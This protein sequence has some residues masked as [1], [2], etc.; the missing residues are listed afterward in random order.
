M[1]EKVFAEW[2]NKLKI[3]WESK[4][5]QGAADLCA[6]QTLYF[7]TPFGPPLKSKQEVLKEWESVPKS[8]KDIVFSYNILSVSETMGIAHWSASFT[9]IETGKHVKLDG[10][11]QVKL[12]ESKLAEEF[13][14]WWVVK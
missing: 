2:L 1:T 6:E 12:N 7:E 8:Q 4:N 13:H 11:F 9:R 10:I 5:P 3:A 14:Q